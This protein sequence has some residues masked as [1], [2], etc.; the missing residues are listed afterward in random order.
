MRHDPERN[1]AAYLGGRLPRRKRSAF[2]AH[3]VEC[4]DCWREV[5]LGR[6]GRA[7]AETGR[8]I[9][10]QEL[11][12]RVRATVEAVPARRRVVLPLTAV[13]AVA[14]VAVVAAAVAVLGD[15]D[16]Q[17]EV[18]AAAVADFRSGTLLTEG[19]APSLPGR[20]GDLRLVDARR[21]SAEGR[22]LAVHVY[23]DSAGH[24]VAVYESSRN[25]PVADGA[26]R[27]RSGG[28]WMAELGGL[29]MFCTDEP[30]PALVIGDDVLEVRLAAR[31]LDLT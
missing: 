8:Q 31:E 10:P 29:V 14:A 23:R 17:P 11:R 6:R 7:V 19:I 21:G 5:D 1:A 2:E 25:F 28:F 15:S 4:D 27:A 9:A 3:I 12:E 18:I 30:R 22:D 24:A 26:R 20:L 16:R 13:A